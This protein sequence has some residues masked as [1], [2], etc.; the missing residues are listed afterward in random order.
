MSETLKLYDNKDLEF[1]VHVF[2]CL[3]KQSRYSLQAFLHHIQQITLHIN[4][5]LYA[6]NNMTSKSDISKHKHDCL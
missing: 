5:F 3:K 4:W 6:E 1:I 2:L